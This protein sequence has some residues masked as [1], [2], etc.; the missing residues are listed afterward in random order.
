MQTDSQ[1]FRTTDDSSISTT[2]I[3]GQIDKKYELTNE[4]KY[5]IIYIEIM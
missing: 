4:K 5:G 1:N 2:K 3:N